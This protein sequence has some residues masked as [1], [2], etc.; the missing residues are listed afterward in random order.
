[1]RSGVIGLV[2]WL[3]LDVATH[4]RPLRG[5][6]RLPRQ[7]SIE[8]RAEVVTRNGD[9]VAGST[10]IHLAAVHEGA[11]GVE[12]VEIGRTRCLIRF[13]NRLALVEEV[14]KRVFGRGLLDRHL[15]RAV[16]WVRL[17]VVGVDAQYRDAPGLVLTGHGGK[18]SPDVFHIGAMIT[19]E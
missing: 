4:A 3:P 2:P 11:R 15:R 8:G 17:D 5:G 9:G 14:G 19:D 12:D 13:R 7:H 16:L 10:P 18:R 6:N 1:T